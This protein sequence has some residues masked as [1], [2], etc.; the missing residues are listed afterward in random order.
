MALVKIRE[1]AT[2][3][4]PRVLYLVDAS[5]GRGSPNRRDDVFLVQFLINAMWNKLTD[6]VTTFG[7]PGSGPDVDGVCG[8][9]TIGAIEAFQKWYWQTKPGGFIDGR[10]DPMP[11]GQPFGPVHH[12]PYAIIGLNANFAI[13]AGPDRHFALAKEPGFPSEL[14]QKLFV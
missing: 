6:K 7:G 1:N 3:G 13:M 14:R 2:G 10:I 9:Q 11:P 5:V 12:N 4:S 8:T